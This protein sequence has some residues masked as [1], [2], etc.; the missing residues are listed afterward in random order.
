MLKFKVKEILNK[1]GKKQPVKWLMKHCDF[2]KTKAYKIY[3]GKQKSLNLKDCSKLCE[4][5]ICTPNDFLYWEQRP[6]T[7]LPENHPCIT[8]MVNPD[9]ISD[10][11]ELFKHYKANE[12]AEMFDNA[13]EKLKR[14]NNT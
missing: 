13:S 10:W 6:Q 12:I 1:T 3:N 14:D 11:I 7:R 8:N 5:L 2:T 4:A 9:N